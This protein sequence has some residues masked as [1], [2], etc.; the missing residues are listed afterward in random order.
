MQINKHDIGLSLVSFLGLL[1][2]KIAQR[3]MT[4]GNNAFA[5]HQAQEVREKAVEQ[6]EVMHIL[7]KSFIENCLVKEELLL[8]WIQENEKLISSQES[9]IADLLIKGL[10]EHN[11][12]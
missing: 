11:L 12:F 9:L 6:E 1:P 5:K 7:I 3:K 8:K 2:N 10:K 4:I